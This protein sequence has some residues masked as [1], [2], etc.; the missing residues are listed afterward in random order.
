MHQ[1][2]LSYTKKELL[3]RLAQSFCKVS[4]LYYIYSEKANAAQTFLVK[5]GPRQLLGALHL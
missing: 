3:V 4:P 1:K 2:H 5:Q